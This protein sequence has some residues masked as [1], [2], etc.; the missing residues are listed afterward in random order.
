MKFLPPSVRAAWARCGRPATGGSV[1][2]SPSS[3]VRW[4]ISLRVILSI[5]LPQNA[6]GSV[7]MRFGK[8]ILF[9][10]V[11][12]LAIVGSGLLPSASAQFVQQAILVG[13]GAAGSADQGISVALSGDGNTAI[14]GGR[15]DNTEVGAA[16]VF[17]R[18]GSVWTQQGGKLVGAGAVGPG[19]AAGAAASAEQGYSVALS[20]DGNTAIVGGWADNNGVGAAWVFNR[21]GSVW[22]QQGSKLVGTGFVG[23]PK[24]RRLRGAVRGRE[25]RHRGWAQRQR[26]R[27]SCVDLHS[28][29]Q[30]VDP[31]RQQ[32]GRRGCCRER[33]SRRLCGAIGGREYGPGRGG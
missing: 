26:Q 13:A 22:T 25:H 14:V 23:K 8:P 30:R 27:R 32:T 21:S 29:G 24:S 10:P 12:A 6:V 9:Q 2:S 5:R 17:T 16:W 33:G 3:K 4:C 18:S 1:E 31:A 15:F 7:I 11:F 20:S 19:A 28:L